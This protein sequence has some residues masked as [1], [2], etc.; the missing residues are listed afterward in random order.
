MP[1]PTFDQLIDQAQRET[2]S[3][4][5]FSPIAG[6]MQESAVEWD[7]GALLRHPLDSVDAVLDLGTGGGELLSSLAPLPAR[8]VATEAH[9]PNVV[10]ARQRLAPLNVTVVEVTGAPD[11]ITIAPGE[12]LNTLPFTDAAFPLVINR[13]ESY[14][15]SEVFRILQAGGSFLTQQVGGAHHQQVNQLM[16][17]PPGYDQRWDLAFAA[18]QLEA[19]GFLIQDRREA[20]PQ[21]VFTDVGALVYYLK[22]VPWQIPGFSIESY[23]HRLHA[24]HER[25][26][27][28]G[29]LHIPGHFFYLAAVKR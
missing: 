14:Y 28:D 17:A 23:R 27:A 12:G 15:P 9:L 21:T 22:A 16:A 18:R 13:H 3:G 25:I 1:D 29:P 4:W 11:N 19:A 20:F 6:R 26:Q 7:F 24:I 10:V 2:F 5:D 8:T